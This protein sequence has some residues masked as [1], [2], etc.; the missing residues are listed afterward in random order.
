MSK[1]RQDA[2]FDPL[3]ASDASIVSLAH[4]YAAGHRIPMHFHDL[5]QLV[6]AARGVMTVRSAEGA[7][8][9]PTHRAVWI[10]KGT[11]HTISMSGTVAMR[12]LYFKPR[13]AA[14]LPRQCCVVN[15]PAL[16]R[17]LILHACGVGPLGRKVGWQRHLVD[18]ILDQLHRIQIAPLQLPALK[19]PRA[20]RVADA[21]LADPADRR[22]LAEICRTSGASRRTIERLYLVETGMSFGK[23]RQQLRLMEAMR[24]LAEGSKVTHAALEAGYST[25]SAFIAA[26]RKVLGATPGQYF[27]EVPKS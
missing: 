9:V 19:D 6:C 20:L 22:P 2:L 5:D 18:V 3:A 4:D 16:L 1:M 13:L 7:W 27:I 8:V 11:P 15:V 25:S 24:L 17:E 21:L 12:T 14:S 26:F 10:P 23:W